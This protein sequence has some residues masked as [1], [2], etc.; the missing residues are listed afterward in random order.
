MIGESIESVDKTSTTINILKQV[1][2][3]PDAEK[4]KDNYSIRPGKV[5]LVMKHLGKTK[6]YLWFF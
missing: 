1:G 6:K 2:A 5:L 3:C 4:A